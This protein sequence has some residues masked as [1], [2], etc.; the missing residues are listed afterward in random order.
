MFRHARARWSG[1][2]GRRSRIRGFYEGFDAVA[3]AICNHFTYL[4]VSIK[5]SFE[6]SERT[7][8]MQVSLRSFTMILQLKP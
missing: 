3:R 4:S 6:S 1:L 8:G 7:G 2:W 5:K